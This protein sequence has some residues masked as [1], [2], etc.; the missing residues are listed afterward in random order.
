MASR[1]SHLLTKFDQR[2]KLRRRMMERLGV[3]P[4][5]EQA[6]QVHAELKASLLACGSCQNTDVCEAWLDDHDTAE[7]LFCAARPALQTMAVK[8][9]A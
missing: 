3:Q 2:M 5:A 7:P 6:P 8:L 4:S 1:L 9:Q